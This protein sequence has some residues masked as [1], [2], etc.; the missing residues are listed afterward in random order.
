M[1]NLYV[2]FLLNTFLFSAA[3][4]LIGFALSQWISQIIFSQVL[5]ILLYF[6]T[7]T[8]LFHFGMMN[9]MKGRPQQ[10]IR[11]FMGA[12]TLKLLV[13]IAVVVIYSLVNRPDAINFILTFFVVYILF[14]AFEVRLA[15][16]LNKSSD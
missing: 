14:T 2:K 3:I 6:F 16:Q 11:F 5:I 10:F 7:L 15:L 12:T 9:S 13:H 1:K 4:G 8:I